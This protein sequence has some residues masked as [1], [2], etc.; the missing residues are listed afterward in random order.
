MAGSVP[1]LPLPGAPLL[2]ATEEVRLLWSFVHGDI[3]SAPMRTWLRASLGF[4]PRHT[5]AYAVVE[6]ELWE[7]GVGARG[8]HQPF[9]VS[10]LYEDLC[11]EAASRLA[12]GRAWG[13]RP[14]AALLPSRP[15]YLCTQLAA[16]AREGLAIGYANSNS[17]ALAA[18]AN[19]ARHTRHWCSATLD[20]WEPLA[21]PAC[22]GRL[23]GAGDGGNGRGG[24][25]DD[26]AWLCRLHLAE[27]L[28]AGRADDA[29][30]AAGL[31]AAARR[32]NRLADRLGAFAESMTA[33][34]PPADA[35]V[36]TSWIVAL[37]FFAGWR[38]PAYL[39]GA[40]V[41]EG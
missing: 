6:V 5:W 21:C 16:P 37:G 24:G 36:E 4:C 27:A 18:E 32:L 25:V 38:F 17:V 28:R 41:G 35:E 2:L 13:R 39:A 15:C 19:L 26:G 29:D 11:R 1:E 9:D 7:S 34:G 30:P 40:A 22:L 10:V 8:G 3:M 14:D 33:A 20:T 12:R 31:P 23:A